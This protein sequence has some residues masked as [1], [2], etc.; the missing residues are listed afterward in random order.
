MAEFAFPEDGRGFTLHFVLAVYQVY[1]YTNE[2][3]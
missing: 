1:Q 3:Y 2:A